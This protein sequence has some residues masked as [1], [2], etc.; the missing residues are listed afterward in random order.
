MDLKPIWIAMKPRDKAGLYAPPPAHPPSTGTIA[1][2]TDADSQILALAT[3]QHGVVARWQLQR[4]AA[5][6]H[7]I[8]YHLKNG[9]FVSI[10]QG[11]YRVGPV[12][13]PRYR[14][15]AALLATG[16]EAVLSHV[17]AAALWNLLPPPADNAPITVSS[18]RDLRGRS[19][20]VRVHRVTAFSAAE[21]TQHDGLRLT[22]PAR[23]LLDLA[24][25][26]STRELEKVYAR[27]DRMNLIGRDQI[28]I[29]LARH[30][31]RRG[32]A[33]LRALLTTQAGPTLTRS[34]AEER[35]LILV[36]KARFSQPEMNVLVRGF[37][38][39][40]L[41]NT[42]RLIVEI[43]GFAFHSSPAAFERDRHRDA[44]LAAAGYRVMR[45]TWHKLTREP[46]ALVARLAQALVSK[47]S[48]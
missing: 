2:D 33:H 45:V 10:H 40:A 38:V 31:R 20:G 21:I 4:A 13:A 3:R 15:M 12:A 27:A 29:L 19:S 5:P 8:R 16:D 28:E 7:R 48:P 30:P 39:D 1:P 43:D 36:R 22:T 47:N 26:F 24:G 11:V 44:V 23:T 6:L 25:S 9:W 41:W 34:E 18:T 35:F 14:E 17:S 46:E 42:E 32:I 37:E